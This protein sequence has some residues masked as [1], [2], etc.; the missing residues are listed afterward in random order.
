MQSRQFYSFSEAQIAY[1]CWLV[2]A[3][4]GGLPLGPRDVRMSTCIPE[5]VSIILLYKERMPR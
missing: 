1:E 4:Y 2:S 5:I 3:D